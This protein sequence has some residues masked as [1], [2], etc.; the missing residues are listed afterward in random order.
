MDYQVSDRSLAGFKA[1]VTRQINNCTAS[2]T[3]RPNHLNVRKNIELL[4]N[5]W[6]KYEENSD[7]YISERES[8][9]DDSEFDRIT[10]NYSDFEDQYQSKLRTFREVLVD[11]ESNIRTP[12]SSTQGQAEKVK[13]RMPE[14]R[15]KEFSGEI[16]SWQPFWDSFRSHSTIS[17]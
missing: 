9:L 7:I 16:D 3:Q 2:T 13:V 1:A 14:I 15:L 5:R 10:K 17:E 6:R 12:G 8:E 11:L 4:E